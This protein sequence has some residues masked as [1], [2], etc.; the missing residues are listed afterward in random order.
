MADQK[1]S[2][3]L[4]ARAR[5][6]T[7]VR[8]KYR[9]DAVLGVG[10]MAIVYKATHRNKAEFAI[11]MLL[12]EISIDEEL[13][14]R[15]LRE[16]YAANSV[17][18]PGVV[19]VVDDDVTDDGEAFLVMELLSGRSAD[20]LVGPDGRVPI[21]LASNVVLQVLD[22]LAAAHARGVLHRDIKPA[23][24]FVTQNGTVKLLDFGIAR[25]RELATS[26]SRV[27]TSS[28]AFGTPAFMSPEQARAKTKEIR[29]QTDLFALGAT[30][31]TLV[32]GRLVHE[33]ETGPEALIRAATERPPPIATVAPEVPAPIAAVVDRALAFE[34][35]ARWPSADEM[36]RALLAAH[37]E[38]Y[39]EPSVAELAAY[40]AELVA[41]EVATNE[42][43]QRAEPAR[44]VAQAVV[45]GAPTTGVP[46]SSDR[47]RAAK[48][49]RA[50]LAAA[51]AGAAVLLAVAGVTVSRLASTP[52]A[53]S[54]ASAPTI[55]SESASTP[56]V[57]SAP[58]PAPVPV[59]E[60][61]AAA[62]PEPTHATHPRPAATRAHPRGHCN[63]PYVV[64]AD[65]FKHFKPECYQ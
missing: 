26:S 1:S 19:A 22:V 37:R 55:A 61:D 54:S 13:R 63:P 65:G 9:L 15:F 25:V 41:R 14:A 4:R 12:P 33:A 62:A 28:M 60:V 10:G 47:R 56:S 57:V 43:T 6:G 38:V 52:R 48:S 2:L 16:G 49:R 40:C 7:V 42:S 50:M 58:L 45:D 20:A 35:E 39:G 30:F 51:I 11:K 46:V 59:V 21:P 23:N 32:T 36:H 34:I 5:L 44:P 24:L 53:S 17:K 27:T 3:G 8:G 31:F 64:D 29:E 18:H